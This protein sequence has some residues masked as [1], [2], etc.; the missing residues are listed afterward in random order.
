M[1]ELSKIESSGG[2]PQRRDASLSFDKIIAALLIVALLVA[3][4]I[5]FIAKNAEV[6]NAAAEPAVFGI[7]AP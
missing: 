6:L 1:S 2:T 3:I 4:Q 7:T 5:K